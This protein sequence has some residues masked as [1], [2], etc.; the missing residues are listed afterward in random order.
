MKKMILS[1]I[2]PKEVFRYFEEIC[3]IPH[4]SSNTKKISDYC[5]QF[6]QKN[7]LRV[8]Q[9][10]LNNIMIFKEG[11]QGYEYS[12]PV[13][14]QGHLDMVCEKSSD[15]KIDMDT[16]GL[17][18]AV[19]GDMIYAVGTTLGG[20][21]GIAVAYG[22]A[23]L[24]ADDIPHPPLEVIFTVDEEIGMLGAS[25]IDCSEIKSNRMLNIDSEEEGILLVSCAGGVT[26]TCHIPK[27]TCDVQ[28][29][30]YRITV[31]GL[32][33]GHSGVEIDKGRA[34]ANQIMGRVLDELKDKVPYYVTEINGGKK[35]N[36]IPKET[37]ADIISD[38]QEKVI[39]S[40]VSACEEQF[41]KEYSDT[42]AGL[43]V[44]VVKI[45]DIYNGA[46]M[47]K[48]CSERVTQALVTLPGGVIKMSDD[49]E[50]LVQTSLNMGILVTKEDRV[51]MSFSVRSSVGEEKDVLVKQITH[52]ITEL[53]GTVECAGEY[54]AWEYKKDSELR[55]RMVEI[56]RK[57][58]GSEPE[59]Q[60]IHAGVECGLF[61]GKI[62]HLDCV[63]FGPNI[64][65]IHTVKER[66]SI[67]SAQRTWKYLLEIL[68]SLK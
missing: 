42:D 19:E 10:D 64:Y 35:D 3:S 44:H 51:T 31:D 37:T 40:V 62:H 29:A 56:Y 14:I 54:P 53:G 34:N 63:S 68:K 6:A 33:G 59:V 60:A 43:A 26:V 32:K 2:E 17:E 12:K 1:N 11:T 18:L 49:I 25:Y 7:G 58:T 52:I 66:L 55:Q 16:Q 20:D 38:G 13:I 61:A 65:D 5:V 4:G 9:D 67:S 23:L 45:S 8:I 39:Q 41:R 50:G 47:S 27:H 15:C 36:A 57:K 21:D 30:L 46:A 48:E 22:L 28:G 24:A